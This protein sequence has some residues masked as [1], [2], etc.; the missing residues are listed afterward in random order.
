MTRARAGL[1]ASI[2]ALALAGCAHASDAGAA[3]RQ[4]V[5]EAN[6]AELQECW[7]DLAAE[8]PGAAGSLLFSVD[9]RRDGSVE[10]VD[11]AVDELGIPKLGACTVR[12]I[13]R[14]KFPEDRKRRS[15]QFGVGFT[16]SRKGP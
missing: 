1:L 13:K 5:I 9:L 10:W 6:L 4:A 12:R 8:Y 3:A 14:W 15:M 16:G 7:D 2:I 11:I